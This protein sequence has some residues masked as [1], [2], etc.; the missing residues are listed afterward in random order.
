MVLVRPQPPKPLSLDELCRQASLPGQLGR[1][2]NAPYLLSAIAERCLRGL[3]RHQSAPEWL[4]EG[5]Q[6]VLFLRYSNP[7]SANLLQGLHQVM[8]E[9]LTVNTDKPLANT[10]NNL[11]GNQQLLSLFKQISIERCSPLLERFFY[12]CVEHIFPEFELQW[13]TPVSKDKSWQAESRPQPSVGLL[14]RRR[15]WVEPAGPPLD[16]KIQL[17]ESMNRLNARLQEVT[18]EIRITSG[19]R[20]YAILFEPEGTIGLVDGCLDKRTRERFFKIFG[21]PAGEVRVRGVI[22][23]PVNEIKISVLA[24]AEKPDVQKDLPQ[25][26]ITTLFAPGDVIG[27][28]YEVRKVIG[29]GGFGIVFEVLNRETL[30]ISALKTFRDEFIANRQMYELF[31]RELRLWIGLPPHAFIL[32][33]Y[34]AAEF[35]GRLFVEMAFIAPDTRGRVGLQDFLCDAG[36][37]P[38]L[39]Q[40]L[41]WGIQFCHG[42][43]HANANGM[44]LHRDIKPGNILIDAEGRIR[45]TD[46]GLAVAANKV[47]ASMPESFTAISRPGGG[48]LSVVKT[49]HG[50]TCGTPGYMPPEMYRG[51]AV[52]IQ[53]D[54]YSFGLVLW[55]LTTGSPDS[56]F[57]RPAGDDIAAFL[58]S[59]Y[60]Q[61]MQER[62]SLDA[63]RL[64]AVVRRCCRAIPAERYPSF[65][66]LRVDLEALLAEQFGKTITVPSSDFSEVAY[67]TRYGAG[68]FAI[69]EY[70]EALKCLDRAL[71]LVPEDY[72]ALNTKGAALSQLDRYQEA[73]DCFDRA[74]E[75]KSDFFA[76]WNNRSA[77]L[78]ALG[79]HKEA[80]QSID[81]AL[82]LSPGNAAAWDTKGTILVDL[83]QPDRALQCH[84]KALQFD[85]RMATAWLNHGTALFKLDRSEEALKSFDKALEI[86]PTYGD[87]LTN[88]GAIQLHLGKTMEAE[89][90]LNQA[91][92][93]DPGN[94]I[95]RFNLGKCLKFQKQY[96]TAYGHLSEALR[97]QPNIENGWEEL[98]E[99]LYS[100]NQFQA[101]KTV[102]EGIL[103]IVSDRPLLWLYKGLA[104]EYLQQINE[105]LTAY[106]TFL[107]HPG[108]IAD[109]HR[110][111]AEKRIRALGTS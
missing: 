83:G 4:Q 7:L 74:L 66:A 28:I 12:R 15:K 73:L 77:C 61:Q 95:A 51:E 110:S 103:K 9:S 11:V 41:A 10:E 76:P 25:M 43:E 24:Q 109:V 98:V 75:L 35:S 101:L 3:Q 90:S 106:Q 16:P 52:G 31:Q 72:G 54:I 45:I 59:A 48:V 13:S 82:A 108:R 67:W 30:E 111:L 84:K 23:E 47:I 42:M 20:Q 57:G 36:E 6:T 89:N 18:F 80:L 105:A 78:R 81:R 63:G 93:I 62:F 39:D 65:A 58:R 29:V 79:R 70:T 99:T 5:N 55:Q 8:I 38:S 104:C 64:A 17:A 86:Q 34:W 21:F 100:N 88:K 56:P 49:K 92:K 14:T 68:R 27:G 37:K 22:P 85:P 44:V 94:A 40:T 60:T 107:S 2:L 53:G 32:P 91:L 46:F 102:C 96:D 71:A 26:K 1:E 97:L 50:M 87:A 33:A 69:G 19:G